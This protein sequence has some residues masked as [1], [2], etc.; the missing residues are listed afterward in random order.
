MNK[1]E[2]TDIIRSV[3]REEVERSLPNVLVEILASKVGENREVVSEQRIASRQQVVQQP[4]KRRSSMVTLDG[5]P[6]VME[7]TMKKFSN[8]PILNSILN[9]TDGG[10]PTEEADAGS[11][12]LD[13]IHSGQSVNEAVSAV[14]NVLTRD[15]RSV[16]RATDAKVKQSRPA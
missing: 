3:V 10:I 6:P 1:K 13:S 7:R 2:L 11:S 12:V 9:E 15:F 4:Q 14:H 5:G 8:N 16:L